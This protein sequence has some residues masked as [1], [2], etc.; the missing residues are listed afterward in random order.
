MKANTTPPIISTRNIGR[1]RGKARI[2]I[3]GNDLANKGWQKGASFYCRFQDG[4]IVYERHTEGN[5]RVAGT[6]A[7]PIIDTNTDNIIDSL[8]AD[9]EVVRIEFTADS[10]TIEPAKA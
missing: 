7:R 8:G 9:C 3:E 2:W 5:R 10:I 4:R 1:N 6:M